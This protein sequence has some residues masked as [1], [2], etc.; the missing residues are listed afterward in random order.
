MLLLAAVGCGG[1][2][3]ERHEV[4]GRY[5]GPAF[6]GEAMQVAHETIPDVM[7]AMTMAFRVEEPSE[8]DRLKPG[9]PIAFEW[10]IE[11]IGSH[12]EKIRVLPPDTVLELEEP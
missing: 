8:L 1:E 3:V 5:L 12:A 6:D 11:G 9:D 7:E 10:V 2:S 4:R